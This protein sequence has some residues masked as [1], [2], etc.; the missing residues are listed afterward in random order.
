MFEQPASR[1]A[2]RDRPS[3]DMSLSELTERLRNEVRE[4]VSAELALAKAEGV[5]RAKR[6]GLGVGMFGAAAGLAFFAACCGVAAVVLGL[7]NVTRPWLAAVIAGA[8]LLVLAVFVALPGRR[9]FREQHPPVPKESIHS[10][11]RDAA[12]VR[13]AAHR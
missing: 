6:L 12:A 1:S 13:E 8:G 3:A 9:G 11:K 4:L 10:I 2:E 7:S 5:Q